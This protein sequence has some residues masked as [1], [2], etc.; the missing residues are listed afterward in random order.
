[1]SILDAFF[2]LFARRPQIRM[3][4]RWPR[5]VATDATVLVLGDGPRQPVKL[6]NLS[7][8]GARI[9]S[10]FTLEPRE[11]VTLT[12]PLGPGVRKELAAEVVY[13]AR[14]TRGLHFTGGLRF[15]AAGSEGIP[16]VAAFIEQERRRRSGAGEMWQG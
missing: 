16:D 2:K 4:R 9:V 14:D 8:G 12:V 1:M 11:R 13:C 10:S 6:A 15:S 5:I 7:A 3:P